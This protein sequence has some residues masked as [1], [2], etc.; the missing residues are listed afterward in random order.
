MKA[1]IREI[2][3]DNLT[4]AIYNQYTEMG[5]ELIWK[6]NTVEIWYKKEEILI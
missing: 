1:F 2:R 5:C 6:E 3:I 4:D